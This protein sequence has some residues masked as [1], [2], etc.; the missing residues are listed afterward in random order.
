M[1]LQNYQQHCAVVLSPPMASTGIVTDPVK[2]KHPLNDDRALTEDERNPKRFY[3][4]GCSLLFEERQKHWGDDNDDTIAPVSDA[5]Y[6]EKA[7]VCICAKVLL[8][9]QQLSIQ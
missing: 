2:S 5:F 8:L 3:N 4:V 7:K 6:K 9:R 1:C